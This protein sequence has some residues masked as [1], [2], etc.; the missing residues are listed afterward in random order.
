MYVGLNYVCVVL[1]MGEGLRLRDVSEYMYGRLHDV[2]G[3]IYEVYI[4][5]VC[6][7]VEKEGQ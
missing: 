1:I 7:W 2:C 3:C 5:C 6:V 4:V